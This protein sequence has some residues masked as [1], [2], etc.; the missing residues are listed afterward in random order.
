[1]TITDEVGVCHPSYGSGASLEWSV[2]LLKAVDQAPYRAKRKCE[3][4]GS[5]QSCFEEENIGWIA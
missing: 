1:M 3:M 5:N 4:I 2:A